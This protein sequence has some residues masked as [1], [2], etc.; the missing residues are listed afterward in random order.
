M[1]YTKG[2]W[3]KE[4]NRITLSGSGVIAI[5]PSPTTSDGVMEFI[6]NT[7]LIV[8]CVNACKSVNQDNPQAVAESI[9]EMYEA[10]KEW[11]GI[12][13][14]IREHYPAIELSS[15]IVNGADACGR[16]RQALAKADRRI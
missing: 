15:I 14:Y 16:L 10:C 11:L 9:K 4:G 3:D 1:E 6:A 12:W 13:L 7:N 2:K 8:S 5:C